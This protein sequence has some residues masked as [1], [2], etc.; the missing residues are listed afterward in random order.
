MSAVARLQKA[1]ISLPFN[2]RSRLLFG[3]RF[4]NNNYVNIC[5]KAVQQ[6]GL[7]LEYVK[8]DKKEDRMKPHDYFNICKLAVEQ[9]SDALKFVIKKDLEPDILKEY[10]FEPKALREIILTAVKQ[11]G[12]ALKYIHENENYIYTHAEL[13]MIEEMYN[14]TYYSI[15]CIYAVSNNESALEFVEINKINTREYSTILKFCKLKNVNASKYLLQQLEK[16]KI[17]D[18]K[19]LEFFKYA[20]L[21]N[22]EDINKLNN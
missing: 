11:N 21:H 7:A 10:K 18:T 20:D 16:K 12:L 1:L 3:R 22:N 17:T 6:S 2:I 4:N 19:Y 8:L 9:K 14:A 5:I 15:I 13:H